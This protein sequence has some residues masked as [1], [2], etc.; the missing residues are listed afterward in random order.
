MLDTASPAGI[1]SVTDAIVPTGRLGPSTQAPAGAA[2][3]GT[4]I[5]VEPMLITL[6]PMVNVNGA[7]TGT[8][9]PATL[10]TLIRPVGGT[11]AA[12]HMAPLSSAVTAKP[13]H[14]GPSFCT[15]I[16]SVL[17]PVRRVLWLKAKGVPGIL[18]QREV[19]HVQLGVE[20]VVPK[21]LFIRIVVT[22]LSAQY[23]PV[24]A[25]LGP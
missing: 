10:Q 6:E 19:E 17:R 16:V 15:T 1:V 11:H 14:D 8:P 4:V 23:V 24:T 9:G 25:I 12:P 18:K 3:A 21:L 13:V 5:V 22:E 7:P 20:H 2:P